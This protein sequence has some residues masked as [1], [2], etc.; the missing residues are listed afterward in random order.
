MRSSAKVSSSRTTRQVLTI[1]MY[2]VT[3]IYF[4][5]FSETVIL[6]FIIQLWITDTFINS[7]RERKKMCVELRCRIWKIA[8]RFDRVYNELLASSP[9]T[10]STSSVLVAS[11]FLQS[12]M[13]SSFFELASSISLAV[14]LNF[15]ALN[16]SPKMSLRENKFKVMT[17]LGRR[18][19]PPCW[20]CWESQPAIAHK[21]FLA[22]APHSSLRRSSK[23]EPWQNNIYINFTLSVSHKHYSWI[24]LLS[25]QR[26]HVVTNLSWSSQNHINQISKV[27]FSPWY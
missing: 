20:W 5:V 9:R 25:S 13:E 27:L 1:D 2:K 22:Q 19:C 8:S 23:V 7:F 15:S 24:Y 21:V 16:V 6:V 11:L 18:T 3:K 14:Y 26:L 10:S 17:S 12:G 4:E